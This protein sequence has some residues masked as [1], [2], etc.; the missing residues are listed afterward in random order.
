MDSHIKLSLSG[1]VG[2]AEVSKLVQTVKEAQNCTSAEMLLHNVDSLDLSAVQFIVGLK[3]RFGAAFKIEIDTMNSDLK[4]LLS[5]AGVY[6]IIN[7]SS[8]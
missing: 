2:L 1:R 7:I 5:N 3:E 4:T 8:N 6:E